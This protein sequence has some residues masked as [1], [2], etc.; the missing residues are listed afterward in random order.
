MS[1]KKTSIFSHVEYVYSSV[2][3]TLC[4]AMVCADDWSTAKHEEWHTKEII[5]PITDEVRES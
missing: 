3:C 2:T 5:L 4:G 1:E